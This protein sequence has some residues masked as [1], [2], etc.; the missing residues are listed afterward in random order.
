[1]PKA[2]TTTAVANYE[3]ERWALVQKGPDKIMRAME[4]ALGDEGLNPF[5]LPRIKIPSSGGKFWE[6]DSPEGTVA[7]ATFDAVI[8]HAHDG[9]QYWD[10]PYGTGEQGPPVCSSFDGLTGYGTPGGACSICQQAG[11][12]GN[13]VPY[14]ALY[15]L[16]PHQVLPTLFQ[17]P[18]M[19]LTPFRN[20]RTKSILAAGDAL[21][22][23]V[24]TFGLTQ[25]PMQASGQLYSVAT[26]TRAGDVPDGMREVIEAYRTQF[27]TYLAQAYDARRQA[28]AD[29]KGAPSDASPSPWGGATEGVPG[30]TPQEV[31]FGA[32]E[33]ESD[34]IPY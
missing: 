26:F 7:S 23:V 24:T 12:G 31:L 1:M 27:V 16:L 19:S 10:K 25:R 17:L 8:L 4:N 11:R 13:C 3:P 28:V 5:E 18:R 15:L 32:D 9:R 2:A 14:K 29:F 21:H 33:S 6:I 34:D 22:D 30:A 20:Y